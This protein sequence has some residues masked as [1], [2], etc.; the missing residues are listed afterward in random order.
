MSNLKKRKKGIDFIAIEW[1][2]RI[3]KLNYEIKCGE[4]KQV[5]LERTWRELPVGARQRGRPS[6]IPSV[7]SALNKRNLQ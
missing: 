7:S 2:S 6:R 3:R 5:E 4:Q 1:Y